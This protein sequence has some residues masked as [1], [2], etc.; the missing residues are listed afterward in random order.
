MDNLKANFRRRVILNK[1]VYVKRVLPGKLKISVV[2]NQEVLPHDLLGSSSIIGGF[3]SIN[4]AQD[5]KIPASD[6]LKFLQR[7]IGSTFF[8]GEL[9]ASK[10]ALFH[11][12]N[13]LAPTDCV[14]ES[15]NS[16]TGELRVKFLPK[17]TPLIAGVYGIVEQVNPQTCEILIKTSVTE[18]RGI[19]GTGG[20]RAGFLSVLNK[21]GDIIN[22]SQIDVSLK[23]RIVLAGALIY[24][25][26]LRKASGFGL[27]GIISG[28]LNIADY[29]AL[30]SSAS[31]QKPVG[32]IG[33]SIMATEGFGLIP[34]GDDISQI[35]ET[36][37]GK[38]VF[39]N[40]RL[41]R[42]WLPTTNPDSILALRK[43]ALP[44]LTQAVSEPN[45]DI[46]DIKTG[47]NVRIIW[48][49]FMGSQGKIVSVDNQL[50]VLESGISTFMITIITP[51]KKIKVP[52]SNIEIIQ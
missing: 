50:T 5:L 8:K 36:Y 38:F 2:K 52:Y 48:P 23:G 16:Q 24:G 49:P 17:E 1:T 18:V 35:A 21:K 44:I 34:I 26:A 45:I 27:S 25:A 28:G 51:S 4:L 6:A 41:A 7:P 13:I 30:V 14:V 32:D 19:F 3:S 37:E 15:Y 9:M 11:S 12:K 46:A 10:K 22:E 29:K 43:I 20:E 31:S 42:L 33:I 47:L 39:L 40:G